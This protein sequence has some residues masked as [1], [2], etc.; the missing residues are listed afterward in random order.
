MRM[1]GPWIATKENCS[2]GEVTAKERGC[3]WRS[4]AERLPNPLEFREVYHE[5]KMLDT[6]LQ[7]LVF[8][9]LK[10]ALS[11]SFL[12]SSHLGLWL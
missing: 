10:F 8:A 3:R 9:L 7:A 11:L 6:K 4:R 1:S 2:Y 12:D 5:S